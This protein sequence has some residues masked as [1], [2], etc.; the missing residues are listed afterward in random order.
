VSRIA[1]RLLGVVVV[2]V[3]ATASAWLLFKL[4][5]PNLLAGAD[6]S[7]WGYLTGAFLHFDFGRSQQGSRAPVAQLIRDG[8]PN[9]LAVLAGGLAFGLAA[10]VGGGIWCARNPRGWGSRALQAVAMAGMCAPVYVVGLMALLVFGEDI[11]SL[12]LGV[13]LHY[14]EPGDSVS[15]WLASVV[16]PWIVV[17]LPL[18]AMCLRTMLGQMVEVADEEYIRA[19]RAKGVGEWTILRRHA[20]PAALAPTAMLA[21]SAMPVLITNVVLVEQ[22]FSVP[23]VFRDLTHSIGTSNVPLILGMTAVGA[24]LI[25]VT[26]ALFDLLLLWLDPRVRAGATAS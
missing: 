25:A 2:V 22:V 11:G 8:F 24:F 23:G 3:S 5:R 17:G 7:L 15:R 1:V 13:P 20:A 18:A 12:S 16:V 4:L 14:V 9:D 26:T 19:A 6:Q 10:G 21:S